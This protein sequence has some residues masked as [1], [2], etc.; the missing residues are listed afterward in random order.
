MADTFKDKAEAIVAAIDAELTAPDGT[1]PLPAETNRRVNALFNRLL[2]S[3]HDVDMQA[4]AEHVDSLRRAFPAADTT[5]IVQRLIKQ[6]TQ[7]TATVGV[8]TSGAGLIPGVGTATAMILGTAADVGATFKLQ[9]VL[10]LEIAHAR[11]YPLSEDE[12]ERVVLLV[13][14]LSAG[15]SSLAQ[16]AGQRAGV[17]FGELFAE[18]SALKALPLLGIAASAGTN[19]LS[20]YLI[21]HRADAYFRLG[22]AG[23]QSWQNSLRAISG[24]DEREITRWLAERADASRVVLVS[25]AQSVGEFGKAAGEN[26]S[27]TTRTVA[28]SGQK[29]GRMYLWGVKTFWLVTFETTRGA[30]KLLG[31]GIPAAARHLKL[32]GRKKRIE[33]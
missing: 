32:L 33:S 6:K 30:A 9:A 18:K 19:A 17:K 27:N 28:T 16:K 31:N 25:H 3:I 26:L 22:E 4:A 14:G 7:K 11:N 5:A 21:G 12:Q 15:A 2:N 24:V 8:V 1:S 23:L 13:T 10:V 29:A 20:T